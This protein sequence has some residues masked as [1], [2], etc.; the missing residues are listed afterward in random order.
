MRGMTRVTIALWAGMA[1]TTAQAAETKPCL[2]EAEAQSVFLAVAPDVVRAVATKCAPS[3]PNTAMLRNGLAA[4]IAPYDA[5]AAN[6]WPQALPAIG[7]MAGA[8]TKGVEP[9][10]LKPLIGPMVGAMASDTL[11]PADCQTIDRVLSLVAPLPPANVAGLA[12]LAASGAKG[13]GPFSICPAAVPAAPI[14]K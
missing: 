13:K 12:A 5:A 8:E 7:K 6:A 2:T 10:A 1:A 14:L 4:F 9:A 3:L 11:K